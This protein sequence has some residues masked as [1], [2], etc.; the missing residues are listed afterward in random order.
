MSLKSLELVLK[1][2][3]QT[4]VLQA[5]HQSGWCEAHRAVPLR[6][7]GPEQ[8]HDVVGIGWEYISGS[9]VETKKTTSGEHAGHGG[10]LDALKQ[11]SPPKLL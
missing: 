2:T 5:G 10:E 9:L 8:R 4:Y 7:V 3:A 1:A 11:S 6:A